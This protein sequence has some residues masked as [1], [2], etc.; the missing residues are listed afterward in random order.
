MRSYS[1]LDDIQPCL[2]LLLFRWR[3]FHCNSV[4]VESGSFSIWRF[5][6][7]HSHEKRWTI[8]SLFAAEVYVMYINIGDSMPAWV[9][10]FCLLHN[11]LI[12]QSFRECID[13]ISGKQILAFPP[14]VSSY[15][16]LSTT[17]YICTS[18]G[19]CTQPI[20]PYTS[21]WSL[22]AKNPTRFADYQVK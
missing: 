18:A 1:F 9:S 8:F 5:F 4:C 3:F 21:S 2:F 11:T 12:C 13:T 20:Y 19:Y 22:V 6:L 15:V 7:Q 10:F 14:R 16:V 17:S